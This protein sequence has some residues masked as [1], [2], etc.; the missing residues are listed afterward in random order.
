M[1]CEDDI[2]RRVSV[3][4]KLLRRPR[5]VYLRPPGMREKRRARS[6]WP[7][8][9]KEVSGAKIRSQLGP[10]VSGGCAERLTK[11][12]SV[13]YITILCMATLSTTPLSCLF[14]SLSLS[15]NREL[16]ESASFWRES[17][18]RRWKHQMIGGSFIIERPSGGN[19]N[20]KYAVAGQQGIKNEKFSFFP[21]KIIIIKTKIISLVSRTL[22]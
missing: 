9:V 5:S 16:P 7:V 8:Q 6:R 4:D 1:T 15:E 11:C 13:C 12:M 22:V 3:R 14:I 10:R 21:I 19:E 17:V 20:Q 18:S 2:S